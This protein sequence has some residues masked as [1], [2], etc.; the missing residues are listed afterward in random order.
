MKTQ[1]I[2]LIILLFIFSCKSGQEFED[3]CKKKQNSNRADF[4]RSCK[5]T[6]LEYNEQLAFAT[7]WVQK[8]AEYR[9]LCYQAFNIAREKIKNVKGTNKK[10]IIVDIDETVLD[11]SPYEA[12][13][14]GLDKDYPVDWDNWINQAEAKA[15]PGAL[16]FL[17]EASAKGIEIFYVTNRKQN[18]E[19]ALNDLKYKSTLDNLVKLKFPDADTKHLLLRQKFRESKDYS[20]SDKQRR[21]DEIMKEYEV[22]LLIGDNMGDFAQNYYKQSY[23]IRNDEVDKDKD[24]FGNKYI[25]LPNPMYGDWLNAIFDYKHKKTLREKKELINRSLKYFD[26]YKKNKKKMEIK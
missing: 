3:C 9:A 16:E 12:Y 26:I 11:N 2:Y 7:L 17:K 21:R 15:I 24:K 14:I 8:S 19:E 6:N 25:V 22:L 1:F 5:Y 20:D 23:N 13:L 18:K 4:T 10:A